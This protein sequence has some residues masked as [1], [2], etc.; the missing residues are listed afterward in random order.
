[1]QF[2]RMTFLDVLGKIAWVRYGF[3]SQGKI[4]DIIIQCARTHIPAQPFIPGPVLTIIVL[5]KNNLLISQPNHMLRVLKTK[6][7]KMMGE[8]IFSKF[9]ISKPMHY[10]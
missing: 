10:I 3:L 2:H 6:L 9:R 4:S 1:M 5:N 8:N 7:L